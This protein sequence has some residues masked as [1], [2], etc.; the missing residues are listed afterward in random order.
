MSNTL[1][2]LTNDKKLILKITDTDQKFKKKKKKELHVMT[3]DQLKIEKKK[4]L[5]H[6]HY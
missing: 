4:L 6:D 2:L 1:K 3:H 5:T